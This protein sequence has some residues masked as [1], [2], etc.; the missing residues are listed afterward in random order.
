MIDIR[1]QGRAL[2]QA[3]LTV[4]ALERYRQEKRAYPLTLDELKAGGYLDAL[5]ADP[6]SDKPLSYRVTNGS[7]VLYSLGPDFRDDGGESG[8]TQEGKSKPWI[9]KG[10]TIF[11]PV[12]P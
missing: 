11:W 3:A 7:F 5:P 1:F 2:H 9:N 10:D 4:L 12:S 8:R 6:Y